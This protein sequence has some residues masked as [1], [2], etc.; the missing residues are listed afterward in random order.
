MKYWGWYLDLAVQTNDV[1]L[2]MAVEE[3]ISASEKRLKHSGA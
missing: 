1:C 3:A 2:L